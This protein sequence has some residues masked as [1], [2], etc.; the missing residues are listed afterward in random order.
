MST[1][2]REMVTKPCNKKTYRD[3]LPPIRSHKPLK[4]WVHE[5]TGQ[6]ENIKS[7]L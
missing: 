1:C 4:T 6:I 5:F 7:S 3:E 2:T